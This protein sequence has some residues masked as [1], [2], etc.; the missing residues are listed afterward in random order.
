MAEQAKYG[1]KTVGTSAVPETNTAGSV[2]VVPT[3]VL[4]A[5]ATL[6][7]AGFDAYLVGGCVRDSLRGAAVKDWDITTVAKPDQVAAVFAGQ[8]LFETGSAYGTVTL[9]TDT[10]PLEITT[11]RADGNYGDGRHPDSVEFSSSLEADLTRRD[12]T[13]NAIAY[14]PVR[15]LVDLFD[16]RAD[17]AGKTL[18]A[19][20]DANE[21]LQEDALRIMRAIRFAAT[22]GMTID[23]E[24]GQALHTHRLLLT[25]ISPERISAEL[26]RMLASDGELILPVLLEYGD[27]L[28]VPIPE[29]EPMLGLDQ[30]SPWHIWDTWEHTVHALA[31]SSP[32]DPI[33]RLA[34]LLHDIGKPPTFTIDE[35]GRGHFYAHAP[36]GAELARERLRELRF[37]NET[38][39]M[40]YELVRSHFAPITPE[41]IRRYLRRLG[42]EQLRRLFEVKRCDLYGHAEHA[43]VEGLPLLEANIAALDAAI[44]NN[45]CYT[46]A[47]M[48]VKGDDL[49]AAG[50]SPGPKLGEILEALLD[51]IVEDQLPNDRDSLL[52]TALQ[53]AQTDGWERPEWPARSA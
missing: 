37:D 39:R 42:E 6:E 44:E 7:A 10:R 35:N 17:L 11:F 40:V 45:A 26:M 27:V 14:S 21:R 3:D 33:V 24:L 52:A 16:G 38:V 9:L 2:I 13:I 4:K 28:A 19:V 5:L 34:L 8:K 1:E 49:I 15:G 31:A 12:F 51:G 36:V 20:G 32:D 48:A 41:T 50:I 22:L 43:V 25:R 23:P 18:R 29:I 47:Q 30:R 53:Y 46:L